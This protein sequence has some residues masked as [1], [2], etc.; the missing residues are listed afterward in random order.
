[1]YIY[2]YPR[3]STLLQSLHLNIM[4]HLKVLFTPHKVES[5]LGVHIALDM[6]LTSQYLGP[7]EEDTRLSS[8]VDFSYT[9]ENHVPVR[10]AEIRW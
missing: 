2:I 8:T 7:A 9:P 5:R 4:T 3:G 1:M 6:Q 10:S